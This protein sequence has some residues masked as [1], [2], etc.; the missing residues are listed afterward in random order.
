MLNSHILI[1]LTLS[2]ELCIFP[3]SLTLKTIYVGSRHG[4]PP[5]FVFLSLTGS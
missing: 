4:D 1:S 2:Y 3:V 5:E